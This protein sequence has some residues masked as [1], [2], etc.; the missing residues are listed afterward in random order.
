MMLGMGVLL[1]VF[2]TQLRAWQT[3]TLKQPDIIAGF[4]LSSDR[5]QVVPSATEIST[6][7][8]KTSVPTEATMTSTPVPFYWPNNAEGTPFNPFELT[9][10]LTS[11]AINAEGTPV[12]AEGTPLTPTPSE[13]DL[14]TRTPTPIATSTPLIIANEVNLA[15]GLPDD[16]I[17]LIDVL[18]TDGYLDEYRLPASQV[19]PQETWE[20]LHCAPSGHTDPTYDYIDVDKFVVN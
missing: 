1:I 12:D 17:W 3:R 13:E 2:A 14:L 19:L 16:Q 7:E 10:M 9:P 4:T 11:P 18:R 5:T 8:S 20:D 6:S 15:A